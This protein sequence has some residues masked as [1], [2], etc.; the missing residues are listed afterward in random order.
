MT[1]QLSTLLDDLRQDH[2]NMAVLLN[3]LEREIE[4]IHDGEAADEELMQDIMR[5]M[6]CYSD[7]VH[8]PKEDILYA[9]MQRVDPELARN[10]ERVEPEHQLLAERGN[11]LRRDIE[12]S[13]SGTP[14][15]RDRLCDE[16]RDYLRTLRK[17]MAWEEEDLFRRAAQLL[18]SH[19]EMTIDV[20]EVDESDPVFG[21][22]RQHSYKNL[23][24]NIRIFSTPP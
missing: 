22:A 2:R 1:I 21:A 3:L 9:C 17:H 13:T 23:L 11:T 7:A 12:A 14:I 20:S 5:Y 10:L 6:T 15:P 19:N 4:H 8:H 18:R 24:D 16:A